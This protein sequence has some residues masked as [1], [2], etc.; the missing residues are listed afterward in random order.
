MIFLISIMYLSILQA[1]RVEELWTYIVGCYIHLL[2]H[3]FNVL[4]QWFLVITAFFATALVIQH[5][6]TFLHF[7]F[8]FN[9]RAESLF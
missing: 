8:N 1:F 9:L 3:V 6:W 7:I 2:T 4:L 5:F